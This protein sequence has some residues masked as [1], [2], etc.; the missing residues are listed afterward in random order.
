MEFP[1]QYRTCTIVFY[2]VQGH[3]QLAVSGFGLVP[4]SGTHIFTFCHLPG[5]QVLQGMVLRYNRR[6]SRR[7][8]AKTRTI[9]ALLPLRSIL[10]TVLP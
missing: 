10:H 3:A 2:Y 9:N 4:V 1:I 5:A 8:R 6:K 7:L